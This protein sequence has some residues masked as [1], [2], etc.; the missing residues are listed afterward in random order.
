M[1]NLTK[2]A[3]SVMALTSANTFAYQIT[4]NIN[5]GMYGDATYSLY[6][7]S[8]VND[9]K[10]NTNAYVELTLKKQ[11]NLMLDYNYQWEQWS[12]DGEDDRTLSDGDIYQA[13]AE[14]TTNDFAVRAGRFADYYT[15]GHNAL[16]QG[17]A[18]FSTSI[19]PLLIISQSR[20]SVLDGVALD[21]K[22]PLNDGIFT[23][24]IYGGKQTEK[25]SNDVEK[26]VRF[27]MSSTKYGVHLDADKKNHRFLF[28][29]EFTDID[30]IEFDE[31]ME[32][33]EP[34]KE[35]KSIQGVY[36]TYQFENEWIF[37]D[38]TYLLNKIEKD[39]DSHLE[40]ALDL[41]IGTNFNNI[42]PFIGYNIFDD[43]S[44]KYQT[45]S[46]GVRYD[47]QE[48]IG[49]IIQRDD[50]DKLEGGD[51]KDHRWTASIF[52]NF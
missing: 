52:Y 23:A 25:Y 31:E 2:V 9:I 1:N 41:K 22:V 37:S 43:E 34:V 21:Y 19:S 18:M 14:Y 45:I 12:K 15:K 20:Y 40:N 28:G 26:A 27:D 49:V 48:K 16:N 3:L 11:F 4:D 36:V 29:M 10:T 38:N 5:T 7:A 30:E 51:L 35:Y 42:K 39:K 17:N 44:D 33:F 50:L 6:D 46:Y 32:E 13:Y 24:T 47:Y 8:E